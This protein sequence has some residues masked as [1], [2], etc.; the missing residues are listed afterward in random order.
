MSETASAVDKAGADQFFTAFFYDGDQGAGQ[1]EKQEKHSLKA[2]HRIAKVNK[3][4][5]GNT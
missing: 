4:S 2:T 1:L 3:P 5:H